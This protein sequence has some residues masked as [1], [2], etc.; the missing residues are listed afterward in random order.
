MTWPR[1][2][3]ASIGFNQ[4]GPT[5]GAVSG[6]SFSQVLGQ[7][8]DEWLFFFFF[9]SSQTPALLEA[10]LKCNEV[11][12]FMLWLLG[13]E[14]PRCKSRFYHWIAMWIWTHCLTSISFPQVGKWDDYIHWP[15]TVAMALN[16]IIYAKCL[17]HCLAHSKWLINMSFTVMVT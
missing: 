16:K 4:Q 2:W 15:Y 1:K 5:V 9:A 14:L 8:G 7:F 11:T 6:V 17:W 3:K 12:Y 13:G 10:N